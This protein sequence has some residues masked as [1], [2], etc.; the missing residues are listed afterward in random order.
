MNTKNYKYNYMNGKKIIDIIIWMLKNYI[1]Y[2][3]NYYGYDYMN[4]K[5]II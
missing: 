3:T 4:A 5:K 2:F 1:I